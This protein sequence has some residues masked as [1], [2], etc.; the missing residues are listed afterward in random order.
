MPFL[1]PSSGTPQN[2]ATRAKVLTADSKLPAGTN[3]IE[4]TF[5]R[6]LDRTVGSLLSAVSTLALVAA[7]WGVPLEGFRKGTSTS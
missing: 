4:L 3:R 7:F 5:V 1:N 2:A 6:T